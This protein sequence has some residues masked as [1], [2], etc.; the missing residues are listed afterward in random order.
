MDCEVVAWRVLVF[1]LTV[2]DSAGMYMVKIFPLNKLRIF[3][4]GVRAT[5]LTDLISWGFANRFEIE[6]YYCDV[7]E[8]GTLGP[9]GFPIFGD[10]IKWSRGSAS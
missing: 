1:H 9:C 4:A 7:R 10:N 2:Y 8:K 3:G 6:G 5:L